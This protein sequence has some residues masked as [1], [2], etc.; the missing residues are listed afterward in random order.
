MNLAAFL[1]QTFPL[2]AVA[3]TMCCQNHPLARSWCSFWGAHQRGA[4][5]KYPNH[6][7]IFTGNRAIRFVLASGRNRRR[8]TLQ[9]NFMGG[10]WHN[11]AKIEAVKSLCSF[12]SLT[13]S[14]Y[15]TDVAKKKLTM[16]HFRTRSQSHF[17][18][19][20]HQ[21]LWPFLLTHLWKLIFDLWELTRNKNPKK[22]L[23]SRRTLY[24]HT[25]YDT[26][27][28]GS[29]IQ[30]RPLKGS[31]VWCAAEYSNDFHFFFTLT[32]PRYQV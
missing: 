8:K 15:W 16:V 28:Q 29:H 27:Q 1:W 32:S 23:Y 3:V 13:D 18:H 10:K 12:I 6:L 20:S 4:P 19:K 25:L 9:N 22:I 30:A 11:V 26:V 17:R 2:R 21:V 14:H 31:D 5:Q 7:N 24:S